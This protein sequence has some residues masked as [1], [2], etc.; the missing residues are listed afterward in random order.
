MLRA[1]HTARKADVTTTLIL[2]SK[3]RQQ[4]PRN[5]DINGIILKRVLNKWGVRMCTG[6]M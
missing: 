2:V 4:I 1:G 6:F 5:T 3:Y